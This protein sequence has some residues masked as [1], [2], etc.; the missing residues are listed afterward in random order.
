M[1]DGLGPGYAFEVNSLQSPLNLFVGDVAGEAISDADGTL[2]NI[3]A[4]RGLLSVLPNEADLYGYVDELRDAR[5]AF[6]HG[7]TPMLEW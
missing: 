5:D 1:M 2:E 3:T 7:T 6:I 4:T